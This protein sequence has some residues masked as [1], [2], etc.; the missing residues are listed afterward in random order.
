[1]N[2]TTAE[3]ICADIAPGGH[4]AYIKDEQTYSA[5]KEYLRSIPGLVGYDL[6]WIG[7]SYNVRIPLIRIMILINGK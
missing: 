1:M 6:A 2:Y 4:L 7:A 3:D 5:V